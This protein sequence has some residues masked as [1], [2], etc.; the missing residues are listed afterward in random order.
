MDYAQVF[1][2]LGGWIQFSKIEMLQYTNYT[3]RIF[4]HSSLWHGKPEYASYYIGRPENTRIHVK[5]RETLTENY[6]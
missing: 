2:Y 1:L 5:I 4:G 6:V 3:V